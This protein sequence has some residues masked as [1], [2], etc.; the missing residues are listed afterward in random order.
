VNTDGDTIRGSPGQGCS[1]FP[2]A[3]FQA[4]DTVINAGDFVVFSDSSEGLPSSWSWTF[5]GGIPGEFDG[6]TPPPIQYDSMGIYTVTLE[7]SNTM[8][9]NTCTRNNYIEVGNT[10]TGEISD[11]PVIRIIP[12]PNDGR[13]LLTLKACPGCD[14]KIISMIGM[15]ITSFNMDEVSKLMDFQYLPA[16]I[17]FI[18]VT[19]KTNGIQQYSRIIAQY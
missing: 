17:Y 8:G 1:Y 12:N 2:K 10:G 13:F 3:L 7:V 4:D 15:E 5:Q 19:C 16:G 9:Q 6:Q 18:L 14:V 11:Q